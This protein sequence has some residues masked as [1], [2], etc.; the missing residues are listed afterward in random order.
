MSKTWQKHLGHLQVPAQHHDA[1]PGHVKFTFDCHKIFAHRTRRARRNALPW[2]VMIMIRWR[3][4]RSNRESLE[5]RQAFDLRD[6]CLP[7]GG[8]WPLSFHSSWIYARLTFCCPSV[9]VQV[10]LGS[11]GARCHRT[12]RWGVKWIA[13]VPTFRAHAR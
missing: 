6:G 3:I 12:A 2:L 10:Q 8:N 1:P 5:V 11:A 13:L 9:T 7:Y 4:R